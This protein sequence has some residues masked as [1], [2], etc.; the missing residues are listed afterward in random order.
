M[1][2][3]PTRKATPELR[4]L[5]R[6]FYASVDELGDFSEIDPSEMPETARRLLWHDEHMT[7]TVEAFHGTPVDVSVLQTHHTPTHY[8]RRIL[9]NRQSDG[10]VVQFGIVRLNTSALAE[11]VREEIERQE[12]PLGRILIQHNVLREVRPLSMWSVVPGTNLRKLFGLGEAG[13][14]FGRTALIYCDGLPAVELL[15]IVTPV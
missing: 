3:T 8:S 1:T 12:T 14:C 5:C 6:L 15:E 9:L 11:A 7:E 4:A 10:E 2:A 13:V